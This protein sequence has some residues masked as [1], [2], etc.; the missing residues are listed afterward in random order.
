MFQF[1]E[2]LDD[3][4]FD[5]ADKPRNEKLKNI[6]DAIELRICKTLG[7]DLRVSYHSLYLA[8][9]RYSKDVYG[10]FRVSN[11]LSE[12]ITD[13]NKLDDIISKIKYNGGFMIESLNPHINKRIAYLVYHLMCQ[14]PFYVNKLDNNLYKTNKLYYIVGSHFNE[15]II[16][17]I[18]SFILEE[19]N[20][21]FGIS[22]SNIEYFLHSIR[23]RNLSRSSLELLFESLLLD[24]SNI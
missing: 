23:H 10:L 21:T 8:L 5:N 16:L 7:A 22:I 4:V 19:L 13:K 11:I 12:H 9:I 15:F 18:V 1:S 3:F 17:F 2:L 20:I 24:N 14:K 6:V